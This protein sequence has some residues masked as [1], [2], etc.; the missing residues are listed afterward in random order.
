[1][2]GELLLHSPREL[3]ERTIG[4]LPQREAIQQSVAPA[5]GLRR[6]LQLRE[7]EEVLSRGQPIVE[8]GRFGEQP[9]PRPQLGAPGTSWRDLAPGDTRAARLRG[10]EAREHPQ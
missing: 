2:D 7:I 9:N 6:P 8:T 4:V 3:G 5:A 1:G 10:I